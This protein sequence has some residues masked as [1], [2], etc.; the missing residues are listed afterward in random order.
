LGR[1]LVTDDLRRRE[2]ADIHIA[3]REL[4][5]E[6]GDYRAIIERVTANRVSSAA[7]MT[8]GERHELL[9]LFAQRGWFN[10][11]PVE[12]AFKPARKARARLVWALW[13]ELHRMGA[14]EAKPPRAMDR[15]ACRAFCARQASI[16][17]ATDPDFLEDAQLVAVIEALKSWVWR[18]AV[19]RAE[20]AS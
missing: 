12:R 18:E 8:V 16:D 5:L 10:R 20:M 3:K 17:V 14:L 9:R 11:A 6:D 2:L 7:A 19:K 4:R 15:A 1:L 13:G